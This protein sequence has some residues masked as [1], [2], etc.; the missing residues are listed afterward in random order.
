MPEL[1]FIVPMPGNIPK[2]I[3]L[4]PWHIQSIVK[5]LVLKYDFLFF[6]SVYI[7]FSELYHRPLRKWQDFYIFRQYD[8]FYIPKST[9]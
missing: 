8:Y 4:R 9:V 5:H 1:K 2:E 6:S 3:R 7:K